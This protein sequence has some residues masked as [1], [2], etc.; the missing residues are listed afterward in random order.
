MNIAA[1]STGMSQMKLG[2]AVNI[3]VMKIAMDTAKMN[4][5][6]TAKMLAQI[7]QPHLGGN[8]DIKA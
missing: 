2:Q 8:I 7:T 6:D 1:L 5:N 4:G 3:A